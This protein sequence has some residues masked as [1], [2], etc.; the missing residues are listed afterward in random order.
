MVD[1]PSGQ[2]DQIPV[3]GVPLRSAPAAAAGDPS[4]NAFG[5]ARGTL[6]SDGTCPVVH[7]GRS[8]ATVA[9]MYVEDHTSAKWPVRASR[10]E[11]DKSPYVGAYYTTLCSTPSHCVKA[12]EGNFGTAYPNNWLG[13][14]TINYSLGPDHHFVSAKIQYNN[15]FAINATQIRHTTCMEQGHALG[16]EHEVAKTSC[17][18]NPINPGD[19]LTLPS[20]DDYNLIR[21]RIYNHTP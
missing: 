17:M 8:P 16:L 12:T 6:A 1:P 14:T 13:L 15:S 11:W 2:L 18:Y 7:W 19:N 5:N 21:Y 20:G 10:I 3:L 9:T 4:C